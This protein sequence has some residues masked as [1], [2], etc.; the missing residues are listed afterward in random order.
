[1]I[2]SICPVLA[3]SDSPSTIS[4]RVVVSG[5]GGELC[6]AVTPSFLHTLPL[7]LTTIRL[8]MVEG[9]SDSVLQLGR[10]QSHCYVLEAIFIAR[11]KPELCLQNEFVR[12]L[13]LF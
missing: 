13:C 3:E 2:N 8:E 11:L 4:G 9:K 1:M 10:V 7:P 6:A 12:S 5:V